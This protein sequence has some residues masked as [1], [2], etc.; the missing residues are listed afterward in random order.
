MILK[1]RSNS[2]IT[3]VHK[4][5]RKGAKLLPS[6]SGSVH[7][8]RS[9][10]LEKMAVWTIRGIIIILS[11]ASVAGLAVPL[12]TSSAVIRSRLPRLG[13]CVTRLSPSH[14][15]N[16]DDDDDDDGGEDR[17]VV[18]GRNAVRALLGVE[19]LQDAATSGS[20]ASDELLAEV[21]ENQPS[22]F[23]V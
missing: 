13:R 17:G 23:Q 8:L 5:R 22:G 7:Y 11:I 12:P 14:V 3:T 4:T 10:P 21:L 9:P 20:Q 2:G 15:S 16:D 18:E 1:E 19:A 6:C